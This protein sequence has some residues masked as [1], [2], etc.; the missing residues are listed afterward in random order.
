MK[1]IK[2][3]SEELNIFD[4]AKRSAVRYVSFFYT[5]YILTLTIS[6]GERIEKE[7][8]ISTLFRGKGLRMK[9]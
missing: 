2:M 7:N 4:V 3:Y 8:E 1:C 5:T 9:S 6:A